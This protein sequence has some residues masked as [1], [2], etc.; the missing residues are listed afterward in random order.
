VVMDL[1][2]VRTC[3]DLGHQFRRAF[4][5]PL[6]SWTTSPAWSYSVIRPRTFAAPNQRPGRRETAGGQVRGTIEGNCMK[7][8]PGVSESLGL[9]T[10]RPTHEQGR[11]AQPSSPRPSSPWR[12]NTEN[13][14]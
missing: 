1:A 4:D 6:C 7:A 8:I 5:D 10:A 9:T 3:P 11:T 2:D 13:A 12:D 14:H